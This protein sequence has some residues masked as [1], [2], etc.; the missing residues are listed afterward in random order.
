MLSIFDIE[1][2][3]IVGCLINCMLAYMSM[4]HY[5][6]AAKVVEFLIPSGYYRDPEIYF[7]KAQ[8]SLG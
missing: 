1:L 2:S 5:E 4:N 7:R 6:E 3:M 8:V